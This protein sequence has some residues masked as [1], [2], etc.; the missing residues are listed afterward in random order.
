MSRAEESFQSPVRWATRAAQM[1]RDK[2]FR[3]WVPPIYPGPEALATQAA[4]A[5]R[6][7]GTRARG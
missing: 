7:E 1:V 6:P 4:S 5:R 2:R 3:D